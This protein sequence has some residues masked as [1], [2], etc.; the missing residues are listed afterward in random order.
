MSASLELQGVSKRYAQGTAAVEGVDATIGAGQFVALLGPSGCGKSTVLRMMAGL[1][2]PSAGSVRVGGRT[3]APGLRQLSFVFQDPTLMPWASA[4]DNVAL[5]LRLAG[6]D[7][8]SARA[9][10]GAALAAVGLAGRESAFP[11]ELSG[12]MRMRVS[13]ARALVTR[14]TVLLLDEPFGAL[15]EITRQRLNDDLRALWSAQSAT[16]VFVTHS[17]Q[18]AVYLGERVL[19]MGQ[20]PGRVVADL[21]VDL[22]RVRT[23]GLRLAPEFLEQCRA[24][25]QALQGAEAGA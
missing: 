5:P 3:A 12:G 23:P 9:A 10:A 21:A 16:A 2:A 1:E 11:L 24:V 8:R 19:V 13:L 4:Q 22:P 17:V 7:A 14:P 25:S 15:D 20:R 6:Q 18:E